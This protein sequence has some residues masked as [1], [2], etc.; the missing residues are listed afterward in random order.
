MTVPGEVLPT[1]PEVRDLDV[2]LPVQQN[3]VQLQVAVDHV[4]RV[5]VH[6][7]QRDLGRIQLSNIFN[8]DYN[9]FVL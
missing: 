4:V 1:H 7:R 2:A 9:I 5:Q 6:Q 3:V 8:V